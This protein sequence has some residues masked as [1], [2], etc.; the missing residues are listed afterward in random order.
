MTWG[1]AARTAT[2]AMTVKAVKV[3][4]QS[5]LSNKVKVG[6]ATMLRV[7]MASIYTNLSSTMAANFQSFSIAAA[8]SSSL[9]LSVIT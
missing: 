6:M 5:L 4:R 8:S 7:R 2:V 3:M 1:A 9:S